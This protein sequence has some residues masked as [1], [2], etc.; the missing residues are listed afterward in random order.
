MGLQML[1]LTRKLGEILVI[2][3]DI[4]ITVNS[5]PTTFV[6]IRVNSCLSWLPLFFLTIQGTKNL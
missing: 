5:N 3:D 4:K 2:G 6:L 1:V